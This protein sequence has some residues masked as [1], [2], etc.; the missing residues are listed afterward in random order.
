MMS[1]SFIFVN[2]C[3]GVLHTIFFHR[4][5]GLV[6]PKDVDLELF[7]ITY[8][9]DLLQF[10]RCKSD[11]ANKFTTKLLLPLLPDVQ[12]GDLDLEKKIEEKID[13][14]IDRVEKHPNKKYQVLSLLHFSLFYLY[15]V[16]MALLAPFNGQQ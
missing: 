9:S 2:V 7:D 6:R 5:L 10:D 4:A 12:C 11:Y 8:V 16:Q 13:Q 3:A 14:F 1:K 15:R